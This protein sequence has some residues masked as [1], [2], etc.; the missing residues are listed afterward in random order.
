MG[1]GGSDAKRDN[2]NLTAIWGVSSPSVEKEPIRAPSSEPPSAP[3]A[4]QRY[5]GTHWFLSA[6]VV[7]IT[8][9]SA[10]L[11][12]ADMYGGRSAA[13]VW[14]YGWVTALSTG[15]GAIP[16]VVCRGG[17]DWSMG[18]AS[19][20]AGGMMCAASLALLAEG[21]ALEGDERWPMTPQQGVV[22]GVLSGAVFVALSEKVLDGF[23]DVKL[24]ILDG[25]DARK[26]MLI[27]AVM[28]IHS[29]SEG[30][31]IGV[32]FR[33]SG[34][35]QLGMMVTTTLAVHNVPEGF[36]VSVPLMSRGMSTL[37]SA[38]WSIGTSIPQPL[39]AV[40][41]FYFAELFVVIQ[42]IGLGFAA[43]A[44]FWVAFVE[45]FPEAYAACGLS[46]TAAVGAASGA[47]MMLSHEYLF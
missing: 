8:V 13:H 7:V 23:G 39:M 30:I 17:S 1:M 31:A 11:V 19:A 2:A 20:L 12:R 25:V 16:A 18:I 47:L 36:A 43:G 6:C 22:L 14:W 27:V 3:A 29:F 4:A 45:L 44:M 33:G 28:A 41:A 26:A 9:V 42:P 35:P 40:V 10:W 32:S 15:L 46:H 5:V 34:P 21:N 38:L 24:G 37:G